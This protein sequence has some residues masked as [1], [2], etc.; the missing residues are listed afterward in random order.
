MLI[1]NFFLTVRDRGIV[2]AISASINLLRM[3]TEN[4]LLGRKLVKR[5]I[6]QYKMHLDASDSGLCRGLILFGTMITEVPNMHR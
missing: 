2:V 6:H 1:K 5:N 3:L 4:R